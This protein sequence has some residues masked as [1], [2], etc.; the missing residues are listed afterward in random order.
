MANSRAT[1]E[2]CKKKENR[3][4]EKEQM[5]SYKCLMKTIKGRKRMEDKNRKKEQGQQI[6]N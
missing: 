5:E 4:T 1:T 3:Y 6:E 2:K